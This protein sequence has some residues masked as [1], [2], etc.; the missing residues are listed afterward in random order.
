[1]RVILDECFPRRLGRHLTGIE[2]STVQREGLGGLKNGQLLTAIQGKWDVLL[3]TDANLTRQQVIAKYDIGLL[4]VRSFS[5]HVDELSRWVP[6]IL[7]ALPQLR[8]GTMQEVG[9]PV[10]LRIER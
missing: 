5:N 9:D 10:L 4:V 1:M 6:D 2:W 8:K 3:T 7:A